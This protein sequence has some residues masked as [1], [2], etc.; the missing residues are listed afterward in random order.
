[1]ALT[2][3]QIFRPKNGPHPQP[4]LIE[5]PEKVFWISIGLRTTDRFT[6][7]QDLYETI[8]KALKNREIHIQ[9]GGVPEQLQQRFRVSFPVH[10]LKIRPNPQ[11]PAKFDLKDSEIEKAIKQVVNYVNGQRKSIYANSVVIDR[12]ELFGI[13]PEMEEIDAQAFGSNSE[14]PPQGSGKWGL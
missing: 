6:C 9:L 7:D 8:A 12:Q 5:A 13:S 3:Q 2:F 14:R 10:G 1:M 11:K 4:V